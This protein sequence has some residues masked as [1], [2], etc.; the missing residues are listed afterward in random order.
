MPLY[1]IAQPKLAKMNALGCR[2]IEAPA[3]QM[4]FGNIDR[5]HRPNQDIVQRHRY[6]S[7]NF[8]ASENPS[9]SDRQQRLE[10]IQRGEAKENSDR[11]SERNGVRRV[12]DCHQG[13]VVCDQPALHSRE[14]FGQSRLVNRL[15]WL[16]W[17]GRLQFWIIHW[18]TENRV[19]L[20]IKRCEDASHSRIFGAKSLEAIP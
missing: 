14:W 12:G 1:I 11:R 8:V 16:L 17:L 3:P 15:S 4:V 5:G 10:W 7:C 18:L 13:H 9:H 6:R 20:A 2:A 19:S